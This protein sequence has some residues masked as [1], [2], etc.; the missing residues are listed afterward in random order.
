MGELDSLPGGLGERQ[1]EDAGAAEKGAA[2]HPAG[3]NSSRVQA[4]LG[5]SSS[6]TVRVVSWPLEMGQACFEDLFKSARW[7][8]GPFSTAQ[9]H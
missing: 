5:I 4:S 1:A 3:T 9:R 2:R 7:R 8:R 6:Q